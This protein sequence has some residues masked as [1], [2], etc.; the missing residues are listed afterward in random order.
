MDSNGNPAAGGDS[1]NPA[2]SDTGRYVVFQ[3]YATNLLGPGNDTNGV[4]DIFRRDIS[5]GDTVLV[6]VDSNGNPAAGGDSANPYVSGNGRYV[7]FQSLANNL[8][9]GDTN[10]LV[11]V[12]VH[13]ANTDETVR[14]SIRT[15]EFSDNGT[16][17]GAS[18]GSGG[19]S[20]CFISAAG[21]G[22]P[23]S[24]SM[25]SLL[26]SVLLGATTLSAWKRLK[27][28]TKPRS[29]RR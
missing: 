26:L 20:G 7:V 22:S 23:G 24:M 18:S 12:F 5:T 11:D 17:T 21:H 15:V 1:A 25:V 6:N 4:Q 28:P 2:I 29:I 27:K 8:V 10:G 13:D 14:L 19:G 3:S 9:S 16:R